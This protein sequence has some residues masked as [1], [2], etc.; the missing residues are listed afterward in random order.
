[1]KKGIIVEHKKRHTIVM[2]Q[3][4]LFHKAMPLKNKEIGME[5]NFEEKNSTWFETWGLLPLNR[6]KLASMVLACLLIL[7]P[8]YITTGENK[9]YA[10][11][12]MDINPS[13]NIT[14]DNEYQVLSM[15]A[16]NPD[17]QMILDKLETE[18]MSL[19]SVSEKIIELSKYEYEIEKEHPILMAV[20]YLNEDNADTEMLRDIYDYY[21][22]QNYNIAIYEVSSDIRDQAEEQS[23]SM[24]AIT[25]NIMEQEEQVA[26]MQVT[27]LEQKDDSDTSTLD[28]NELEIIQDFYNEKDDTVE[29]EDSVPEQPPSSNEAEVEPEEGEEESKNDSPLPAQANERAKE[30]IQ[31]H[32]DRANEMKQKLQ[33]KLPQKA[34]QNAV[35]K[36][37]KKNKGKNPKNNNK[38]KSQENPGQ[39][40]QKKQQH[41]KE[42]KEN[43]S[44]KNNRKK[45][46][47]HPIPK[48]DISEKVKQ[49]IEN[50]IKKDKN[51]SSKAIKNNIPG[52]QKKKN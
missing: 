52:M 15:K 9:V 1:M 28:E 43:N 26:A 29:E 19:Q 6:W 21:H 3:N 45:K 39:A 38:N 5:V 46:Q 51:K 13:V 12:S 32:Q 8:F 23:V 31:K 37:M 48:K 35:E 14:I 16:V 24:N 36:K 11:V 27:N 22:E 42:K 18:D 49:K 30:N 41:V 10:I 34:S 20:S 44:A 4:G 25:A 17:A 40:K 2:D 33:E 50:G 7:S 47:N